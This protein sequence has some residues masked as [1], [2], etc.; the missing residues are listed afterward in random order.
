[1]T[2]SN[3]CTEN[4]CW[5]YSTNQ[6]YCQTAP[7]LD[8]VW[9]W[10]SCNDLNCYNWDF[11]NET[12][13]V[14]NTQNLSCSWSSQY[15]NKEACWSYASNA[16]CSAKPGCTWRSYVY[17]GW[18]ERI[19]CWSW[20]AKKGGNQSA[21][22]TNDAAYGL[23][24]SW[25]SNQ[26]GNST[27][28]WCNKNMATV[29]CSNK[30]TERECMNTFYCWWQYNDWSNITGG[31]V[32]KEPSSMNLGTNSS[33]FN[34]WN[35]GCYIFDMN[36][37]DCNSI[38]G[39]SYSATARKCDLL[40]GHYNA[41][42]IAA[43]GINCTMVNNSALCNNIPILSSCCTW[44]NGNCTYNRLSTSCWDQMQ[45]KS[46]DSCEDA[47]TMKR[48]EELSNYPWYMPC[49]WSNSTSKCTFK[50]SDIF[51]SGSKSLLKI[52]NKKTCEAA[53]GK[54]VVENYCNGNTSIP[55]GRCEY[56]F[57]EEDNCNKACFACE[58]KDIDGNT[59]NSSNAKLACKNSNLGI[60]EFVAD[61]NAPNGIGYCKAKDQFK[62]GVAVD[63]DANCGDCTFKGDNKNN[64]TTKRSSYYCI[65]SKSNSDGGGCKWIIDN[66]T[67]TGGYC[68]NK[69]EKTCVDVCDRCKT[70]SDCQS[71]GRTSV[72]NQ[73]GSCKWQGDTTTG[74][75]VGN[76]G[77]TLEICWNGMDDDNN[78]AIDCSDSSCFSDSFCGFVSGNCFGWTTQSNCADNDCEWV[79]DSWGSWCDSKG[80]QCWKY[81]K[82]ESYC[83]GNSNCRWTN[84][85][86]NGTGSS[87]C[88]QDWKKGEACMGLNITLCAN[89]GDCNWTTD[90]WCKGDGN[91]TEWCKTS[92]G[93]CDL[94]TF[95]SKDCWLYS[96][97][98]TECNDIS[99]C[100]W[101][102]D[103]YSI[104][105]CEM[106]WSM[107][108]W[109]YTTNASCTGGGCFFQ[110]D[111][112]G[113]WCINQQDRCWKS[114]LTSTTCVAIT[115][116]SGNSLCSWHLGG[117]SYGSY[118]KPLCNNLT[119]NTQ[120]ACNAI[121]GCA[122]K[123]QSGWCEEANT[124]A[125]L[126]EANCRGAQGVT[127]KCRWK[128]SG[129]CD[130]KSGGFS[131]GSMASGGGMG[132]STG[133]DC[134]RYDSNQA[135]CTNKSLINISCG[136]FP[137][138]NPRCDIDWTANCWQYQD[139]AT[140][141]SG[142]CWWKAGVGGL[143]G[144]C[145]N[146]M[147]QCWSNDTY[148]AWNNTN[149]QTACRANPY[150]NVSSWNTCEP[151][152]SNATTQGACISGCKWV[153]GWC[154]PATMTEMFTG[155]EAG[156]PLPL[157]S[158]TCPE[159]GISASVDLCGFGLKDMGDSYGF[160]ANVN[161]FENASVCNKEIISSFVMG[162]V[163]GG[164]LGG[165]FG[166]GGTA[167]AKTGTGNETVTYLVYVDSDGS[168]TGGCALSDNSSAV[169]Y[170]F[171]FKY[172]AVW[173]TSTSK[174]VETLNS[175][176]CDNSN[177][178]A[179]DIKL[180]SWNKKMCSEIGGPMLAVKKN[181]LTRF[182]ILY[183][184]T[185]DLRIYVATAGNNNNVSSPSDTAGPA[186]VTPGSTDFE[187]ENA[188]AFGSD[189]AKFESILKKGFV[190][191]E[192]C[193]SSTVD[194]DGDNT[195]GCN[196]WD[197]QYS[198]ACTGQGVNAAG[199]VDTR[200]PLV[201][202]VKIEEYT[203]SALIMYDTNK[204][205]NG[206]LIL[207]GA[208]SDCSVIIN[209]TESKGKFF[210]N[211]YIYPDTGVINNNS[212]I[213][214][215]WHKAEIFN[216]STILTSN[217]TVEKY[218]WALDSNITY[219]YKLKVCDSAG[220]CA[221]SKCSNFTTPFST[222]R[223]LYCDFI[224]RIKAQT[225]WN[226][227][228][229]LD[230]DGTYEHTQG[231]VC[232]PNAGMKTNYTNGRRANIK[233][234]KSDNLTYIEF[235]NVTLT[236]TGLNDKVRTIST[237][238]SM[239]HDT[240]KGII[241]LAAETR[242]K[243]INNLYPERCRVKVPN[244][245]RCVELYHC[246]DNGN[247]CVNRTT[248][249]GG[250]PVNATE[251]IWN[252]PYCEFSSYKTAS[253]SGSSSSS[254]GGGSAV[255][256]GVG[257]GVHEI[258]QAEL[259]NGYIKEIGI[260]E[261][262]SFTI[263]SGQ[264]QMELMHVTVTTARI[265]VS[266]VVQDV[267]MNVGEAKEFDLDEDEIIDIEITLISTNSELGLAKFKIKSLQ[268]ETSTISQ[269][270]PADSEIIEDDLKTLEDDADEKA[271]AVKELKAPWLIILSVVVLIIAMIFVLVR[272]SK[273][274]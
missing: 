209:D 250:S 115:D 251:C 103:T 182:P 201:L 198:S 108:C 19:D 119:S 207:Y 126:N 255:V 56:K 107:N 129:W 114:S 172:A 189:T 259:K 142:G 161:S 195:T 202:G 85:T 51:G 257:T 181:D 97:S 239:I 197:C 200:T 141:T 206:T 52:D 94:I 74:S 123:S 192:D 122:W 70:Q 204:P 154:N 58:L 75:C 45:Q 10:N 158:D 53:G 174:V 71:T 176:K 120:S 216:G 8:C 240:S 179:T 225:G 238:G 254:T 28:G 18:C 38:L 264:H 143:N 48:C 69:G 193:F 64:D 135:T 229:D 144:W 230:E 98:S 95:K 88:E 183:D 113:G 5:R 68:L 199:Y 44:Q 160:G 273:K 150:C 266:S 186:W 27:D 42:Q 217:G 166:S 24:C 165:M 3:Y 224:T 215:L 223:C 164:G 112:W 270:I 12:A 39:C 26:D 30:T 265:I 235:L 50:I 156:A 131:S 73:S 110:S 151:T 80:G 155:M 133:A 4:G 149:W 31:G 175:Y 185:K 125:S 37:S 81:D 232:G 262:F 111:N 61:T 221:M 33:I 139:L 205:T 138:L 253:S 248:E 87:W 234:I 62:K 233:L 180:S 208:D 173:N 244:L 35:P 167:L 59:V 66:S 247:N 65:N 100:N 203:D 121:T 78:G 159:S 116:S 236:K 7:G 124:C 11:T 152:C 36:S 16:T 128:T 268:N 13:C 269:E 43:S 213:Y 118:C 196:D 168:T 47:V 136:W 242:D 214:N 187:I 258:S 83:N 184:S 241:G 29:S 89:N 140:C 237:S 272:K 245:G 34:E 21:C 72:A 246:D 146:K 93:W 32:C 220:K 162:S 153:T 106:N 231:Q 130:P 147:E 171:R 267:V 109:Q 228:Y 46:E 57:D 90:S 55:T 2:G 218:A 170:E 219:F 101:K 20:D 117:S 60:C 40:S 211:V 260:N 92:G 79:V 222:T 177:W 252:V 137:E 249:A 212:R 210:S 134:Y 104:P 99:G 243:I 274:K 84:G 227:L 256:G 226:V 132:G 96:S 14:N 194:N 91:S 22:E 188:F 17:S 9:K 190:K 163:G 145:A 77:E 15:C 67:A 102:T 41:A 76:T 148:Q 261:K 49:G 271:S 191:T 169:G 63:C 263:S 178:V 86:A 25:N 127:D 6:S 54:W 23:S 82:N 157:G 105:Q 1:M